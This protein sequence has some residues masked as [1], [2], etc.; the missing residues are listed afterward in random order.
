MSSSHV[1]DV[2]V[3]NW[4]ISEELEVC[5]CRVS[6]VQTAAAERLEMWEQR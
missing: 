3:L 5:V 6:M 4:D 2:C 1:C